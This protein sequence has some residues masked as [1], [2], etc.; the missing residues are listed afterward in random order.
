MVLH[1]HHFRRLFV[2]FS[3]KCKYKEK[4]F[5]N[6]LK[7]WKCV[8]YFIKDNFCWFLSIQQKFIIIPSSLFPNL[9]E[10]IIIVGS[11]YP[12]KIQGY[13]NFIFFLF[14][15]EM[16]F[17]EFAKRRFARVWRRT[18]EDNFTFFQNF[19]NFENWIISL[20]MFFWQIDSFLW[21]YLFFSCCN[22]FRILILFL[23]IQS[24]KNKHSWDSDLFFVILG[25]FFLLKNG[26]QVFF[27]NRWEKNV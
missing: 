12:K 23:S 8:T 16:F 13:N 25:A 11:F 21:I 22:N 20:H 7:E 9:L 3:E 5:K 10:I 19:F 1:N 2:P 24:N 6:N 17:E 15:I 4:K 26:F 14:I 18:D 27:E